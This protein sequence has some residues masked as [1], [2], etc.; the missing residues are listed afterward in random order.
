MGEHF[1]QSVLKNT[2][3]HCLCNSPQSFKDSE[4]FNENNQELEIYDVNVK[5]KKLYDD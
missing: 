1:I 5:S 2:E 4:L 3:E